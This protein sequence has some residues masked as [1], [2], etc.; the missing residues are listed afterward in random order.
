MG[1]N[2]D[3]MKAVEDWFMKL[4][5]LPPR[6]RE[7]LVQ[8]APWIS[9]IFG[10]L[11]ILGS[12]AAFGFSAV[13]SP[14]VAMGGGMHQAGAFLIAAVVGLV[15]SVLLL[16]SFPGLNKRR[17][18]GWKLLFWSEIAGLVGAILNISPIGVVLSLVWI[19]VIFQMKA[20]YK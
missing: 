17:L 9:L 12:L 8:I 1:K 11:G 16:A 15:G 3:Y 6:A 7:V 10:I 19:Y 13:L 5:P 20:Y 2:Q 4:P 18:Q 14:F